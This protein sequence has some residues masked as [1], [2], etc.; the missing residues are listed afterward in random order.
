MQ[1]NLACAAQ[2]GVA[3]NQTSERHGRA[4]TG[5]I[6]YLA[7]K[8]KGVYFYRLDKLFYYLIMKSTVV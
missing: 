4:S 2:G 6:T 1:A 3:A 7:Q 8:E 5:L